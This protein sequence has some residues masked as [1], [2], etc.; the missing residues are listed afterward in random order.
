MMEAPMRIAALVFMLALGAG[1]A[2]GEA[3]EFTPATLPAGATLTATIT[4]GPRETGALGARL[5]A[6]LER[7]ANQDLSIRGFPAHVNFVACATEDK[8]EGTKAFLE[9]RAAQF[10]GK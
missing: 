1:P 6:T 7:V 9:K 2:S 4:L 8:A 5:G 10:K 3:L